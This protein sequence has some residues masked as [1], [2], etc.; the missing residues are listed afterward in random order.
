[1]VSRMREYLVKNLPPGM[2]PAEEQRFVKIGLVLSGLI[3]FLDVIVYFTELSNLYQYRAGRRILDVTREMP[4]FAE[5]FQRFPIGFAILMLCMLGFVVYHYA[6]Y[7][8]GSKSI[9]LMRRLPNRWEIHRR[10]WSYP[11]CVS[12]VCM[13]CVLVLFWLYFGLYLLVTPDE[14]LVPGQLYRIW[15]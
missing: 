9:Y 14:C 10:A 5:I 4:D 3:S 13:L 12:L 8:R 7:Y 1:V 15:R 11:L 2:N 6:Y